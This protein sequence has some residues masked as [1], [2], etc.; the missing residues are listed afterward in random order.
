MKLGFLERA[1][2]HSRNPQL[3]SSRRT[4]LRGGRMSEPRRCWGCLANYLVH[5]CAH[6]EQSHGQRRL[7]IGREAADVISKTHGQVLD[8]L[9]L[10]KLLLHFCTSA[11]QVVRDHADRPEQQLCFWVAARRG[12]YD[13][14]ADAHKAV[15]AESLLATRCVQVRGRG[16][17]RNLTSRVAWTPVLSTG[18][19]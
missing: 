6:G 17:R 16:D 7:R 10:N 12:A 2:C 9:A 19:G 1:D 18:R 5:S 14:R 8:P 4:C 3:R 11:H 13:L 15:I